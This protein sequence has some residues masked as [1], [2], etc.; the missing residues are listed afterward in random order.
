MF[1]GNINQTWW[2]GYVDG[3]KL[4]KNK[5][6]N[7]KAWGSKDINLK[8]KSQKMKN[9]EKPFWKPALDFSKNEWKWGTKRIS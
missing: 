4:V 9:Y 7:E 5:L 6:G 8:F 3:L 1:L 2:Q